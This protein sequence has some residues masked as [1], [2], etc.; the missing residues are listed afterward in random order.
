MRT[1]A[2]V[3]DLT[4]GFHQLELSEEW[5][6]AFGFC[7][8]N[9][10]TKN[11]EYFV[12]TRM[13]MGTTPAPSILQTVLEGVAKEA[14][15]RA[16]NP[17]VT[18]KVHVDGVRFI[19][20]ADVLTRIA[21]HFVEICT[22]ANLTIKPEPLVNLPHTTG[23]WLG[24]THTYAP[25][26]RVRLTPKA[27]NKIEDA[28]KMVTTTMTVDDALHVYGV[29]Q[30]YAAA[31]RAPSYL[32]YHAIKFYRRM[33]SRLARGDVHMDDPA[34]M[35]DCAAEA[36]RRWCEWL[37]EHDECTPQRRVD[38]VET[39]M[40]VDA[41]KNGWGAVLCH[42]G[43]IL[44]VGRRWNPGEIQQANFDINSAEV[45][46][47]KHGAQHFAQELHSRSIKIV[48]DNTNAID[49]LKK[50]SAHAGRLNAAVAGTIAALDLA[51]P[52]SVVLGYIS[53]GHNPADEPSRFKS[54]CWEKLT[55][56]LLDWTGGKT[57]ALPQDNHTTKLRARGC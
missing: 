21:R 48:F 10:D 4:Q 31:L 18:W 38:K 34:Q 35:W 46:A 1:H 29:I 55:E 12:A 22:E 37:L 53:S 54:L 51:Q 20:T 26:P 36:T 17:K 28:K 57:I 45:A 49:R 33:S 30:Y 23:E 14:V 2:I 41:S 13:V 32:W 25:A 39:L 47:A 3:F 52:S 40:F 24:L 6:Q 44:H 9:P 11:K 42:G 56:D 50:S 5:Q 8:I 19:A 15:T 16:D 7:V 43:R 27:V